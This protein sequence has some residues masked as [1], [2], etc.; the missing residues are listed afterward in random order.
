MAQNFYSFA[1]RVES[2]ISYISLPIKMSNVKK[3]KIR[4]L[5]YITQTLGN[6]YMLVRI[7]GWDDNSLFFGANYNKKYT[8]YIPLNGTVSTQNI[9]MNTDNNFYDVVKVLPEN[10]VGQLQVE[11]TIDGAYSTDINNSNPVLIE[12]FISE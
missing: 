8:K 3:L 9:Y 4:S 5:K 2:P 11:I 12:L 6:E 1:F 10:N 7:V